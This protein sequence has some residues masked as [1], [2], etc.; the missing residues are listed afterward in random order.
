MDEKV[1]QYSPDKR[2]KLTYSDFEEP[3]MMMSICRF[4]LTDLQTN[5]EINF[6]PLWAIGIGQHGFS[7]SDDG[8]FVSLPIVYLPGGN[9]ITESFFVYNIRKRKFASIHF[10]NCWI[11]K[12]YCHNK[13]L[14]I[15]YD[16]HIPADNLKYPVKDL[17][18]PENIQFDFD[19]L[20]WNGIELLP[21][22]N[23]LNENG[24]INEFKPIDRG[25]RAFKGE[26]PQTT[27]TLIWN[28]KK[29]AEYGDVQSQEWFADVQAKTDKI[30][31][32]V[33][34]SKYIGFKT[35]E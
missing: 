22:F 13:I 19:D 25:W 18:K 15:E 21:Q 1:E 12:G 31:Y 26:L 5:E 33:N 29:F 16:D 35:R 20:Q 23:E 17:A 28:L 32:W 4:S 34:A 8:N 24:V 10:T 30:N 2:Y 11:L 9:V 7:W 3:R 6:K 27:E 14:E